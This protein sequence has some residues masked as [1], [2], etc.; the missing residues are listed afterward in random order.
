M[1]LERPHSTI[2]RSCGKS[3]SPPGPDAATIGSRPRF[4]PERRSQFVETAPIP[5][6]PLRSWSCDLCIGRGIDV[7][8]VFKAP[9]GLTHRKPRPAV[10]FASR[11][12]GLQVCDEIQHL[13]LNGFRQGLDFVRNLL[14]CRHGLRSTRHARQAR[15]TDLGRERMCSIRPES[16]P[17]K[18]AAAGR[19][20][21]AFPQDEEPVLGEGG[22]ARRQA[23]AEQI[24]PGDNRGRVAEPCGERVGGVPRNDVVAAA[25]DHREVGRQ[26]PLDVGPRE[27]LAV[28]MDRMPQPGVG[29]AVRGFRSTCSGYAVGRRAACR[30]ECIPLKPAPVPDLFSVRAATLHRRETASQPP[31]TTGWSTY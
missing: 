12:T 3:R 11:P 30:R 29:S 18:R 19:R 17:V 21:S 7:R 8:F 15:P 31:T 26:E 20:P 1:K 4:I 6:L 2:E 16:S 10:V 14:G 28:L 9:H 24:E 13:P 25:C 22:Q 27:E 5:P 23:I